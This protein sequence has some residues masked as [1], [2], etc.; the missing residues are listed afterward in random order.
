MKPTVSLKADEIG[1]NVLGNAMLRMIER[2][3]VT[4]DMAFITVVMISWKGTTAHA[5]LSPGANP[6]R[7]RT[8]VTRIR[9][10]PTSANVGG[11]EREQDLERT[12]HRPRPCR[13]RCGRGRGGVVSSDLSHLPIIGSLSAGP[14]TAEGVQSCPVTSRHFEV[15]GLRLG[16]DGDW[17]EVV[18]ALRRDLAWFEVAAAG[19]SEPDVRIN[20]A[21]GAPDYSAFG[22]VAASF[23][24]ERNVVY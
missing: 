18:E 19:E 16:V 6:G 9:Y 8:N 17:D 2:R 13:N 11:G 1:I 5:R 10:T 7:L 15:Y 3:V 21:H 12:C 23:V 22:D 4:A 20:I 14:T 24:T